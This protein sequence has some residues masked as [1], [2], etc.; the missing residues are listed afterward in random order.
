MKKIFLSI[1]LIF[2][3]TANFAQN[4]S[5]EAEISLLTIAPGEDLYSVFGH[6]AIRVQDTTNKIDKI[7]NYG[8]FDFDDPNFYVK[9]IHGDLKYMLSVGNFERFMYYYEYF[10]RSV[11]EQQLNLTLE[12]KQ[13]IYEYIE[14]NALPEN[15][16]YRYDFFFNNCATIIRDIFE[17]QL[18][19][20]LVFN[21]E[22]KN[23]TFRNLLHQYM[24][25]GKE[26]NKFGIDLIL[27]LPTDKIA[28]TREYMFLPDYLMFSFEKA[29]LKTKKGKIA[30]AKETEILFQ[31]KEIKPQKDFFIPSYLFWTLFILVQVITIIGIKL[32]KRLY[33]LDFILFFSAGIAGFILF[34]AWF[35]T[36][37]SITINNFN[38]AF[39]PFT[40]IIFAFFFFGKK[41]SKFYKN[42]LLVSGILNLLTILF[43]AVIP[44]ELNIWVFPI[45]LTLL[46][47]QFYLYFFDKY[48]ENPQHKTK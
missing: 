23:Y 18:G 36:S 2:I 5:S 21:D 34:Y 41:C 39:L 44:Q 33:A 25:E 4:L 40:H 6:S 28:T 24:R 42:Y 11:F 46:V 9:F 38:L 12:Q 27:G 7:Y 3:F 22:D 31:S 20:D 15:K 8:T 10:N 29:N 45:I 47:R 16:F 1:S 17:K 14:W 35:F 30:F 43:W 26:W 37:H 19:N 32:K 13:K 48:F